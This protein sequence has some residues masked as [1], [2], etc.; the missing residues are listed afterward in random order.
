MTSPPGIPP[1]PASA[2]GLLVAGPFERREV[3]SALPV[4]VA[5]LDAR[6]LFVFWNPECERVTGYA[7][8]DVVGSPEAPGLLFRDPA[9][10]ARLDA[11]RDG[12]GA[13]RHEVET[14]L[15]T[16]VGTV[17][18]IS[19]SPLQPA[20]GEDGH[21]W[22][23]GVDRTDRLRNEQLLDLIGDVDGRILRREPLAS[24]H[25]FVCT[26]VA[27]IF[28]LALASI[29]QRHPD[30]T[31]RM[32]GIAGTL[33]ADASAREIRWDRPSPE[34][35][36]TGAAIRTGEIQ[37]A[38]AGDGRAFGERWR[39]RDVGQ[40]I[41]ASIAFPLS[42]G[43]EVLGALTVHARRG[44]AFDART[45]DQL[46]RLT[47]QVSLSFAHAASLDEIRLQSLA[48]EAVQLSVVI[49]SVD[50]TIEWVNPAFTAMTG[51]TAEDA[52]GR[53]LKILSSGR[54]DA[55]YFSALWRTILAG[56]SW[57]GET[58]NRRK[59]GSL[60]VEDQTITPV[61]DGGGRITHFVAVKRDVTERRRQ[62]DAIIHLA[63]HDP[64]TDLPNRRVVEEDL[65]RLLAR[66]HRGRPSAVLLVDLDNFKA[67]N[68][69]AGHGVGDSLLRAF[70]HILLEAVRPGDLVGR[71]GGDEFVVL[72]E[73]AGAEEAKVVAGR[74]RDRVAAYPRPED[75]DGPAVGASVGI[76]LV[77]GHAGPAEVLATAYA[78]LYDGKAAGKGRVAIR[79]KPA[80]PRSGS[81]R[82]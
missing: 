35:G 75:Y 8:R 79:T 59:D 12:H 78:A 62:D 65:V 40:A 74:I 66:A 2:S 72:L 6:G 61:R 42:V 5:T 28:H 41:G 36:I 3:A 23:V 10:S 80:R 69:R 37:R 50:G 56:R 4:L 64:L 34:G 14:E 33:A 77:E 47:E 32:T 63:R 51:Y 73:G 25:S 26:R 1:L 44:E 52:L 20:S 15:T 18:T 70:A 68:D 31:V 45:V 17:R 54:H 57:E 30:G 53:T 82:I 13:A 9:Q 29:G 27:G 16:R 46:R 19:W 71:V 48:L 22:I 60:Y 49:T 11:L 38:E 24:I 21:L 76:A 67:V 7:A 58:T 39:N 81:W 43:R 55:A